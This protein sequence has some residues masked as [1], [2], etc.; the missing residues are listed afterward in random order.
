MLALAPD[1]VL[2]GAAA[3]GD[4]RPLAELMPALS[5]HGVRAVSPNGVLGDPAAEGEF[6]LAQLT[7]ALGAALD[8]LTLLPGASPD[9]L[10]D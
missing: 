4:R 9:L 3:A 2:I 7:A 6:L 5:A 1:A 10:N 8:D